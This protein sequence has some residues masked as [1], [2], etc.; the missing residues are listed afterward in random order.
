MLD[1]PGFEGNETHYEGRAVRASRVVDDSDLPDIADAHQRYY[2]SGQT[3]V[4][5]NERGTTRQ[6]LDTNGLRTDTG[7]S[8]STG[9]P[10]ER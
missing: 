1:P 6:R 5:N 9:N 10:Y 2:E 8:G 7:R 3:G 4:Y